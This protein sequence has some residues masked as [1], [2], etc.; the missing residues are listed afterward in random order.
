MV[1]QVLHMLHQQ[2][3]AVQADNHPGLYIPNPFT[4]IKGVCIFPLAITL[5][6]SGKANFM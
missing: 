1:E 4:S 3:Q 2:H 5:Y 6:G